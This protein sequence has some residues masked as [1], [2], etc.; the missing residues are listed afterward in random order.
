MTSLEPSHQHL[1]DHHDADAFDRLVATADIKPSSRSAYARDLAH[2]AGWLDHTRQRR[3]LP[4]AP[5]VVVGWI[6]GMDADG[7][8]L[9]T[10]RCR[11][12][13]L[14][15]IHPDP[16]PARTRQV[17]RVIRAI[18]QTCRH[19]A[20]SHPVVDD[21]GRLRIPATD[22]EPGIRVPTDTEIAE[23]R[24]RA[25]LGTAKLG[26]TTDAVHRLLTTCHPDRPIGMRNRALILVTYVSACRR[27]EIAALRLDHLELTPDGYVLLIPDSKTGTRE[28]VLPYGSAPDTCRVRALQTWLE[29]AAIDTGP[30]FR[31]VDRHGNIA[32]RPLRPEAIA[33]VV[34]TAAQAAGID[35][36]RIGAHSLRRGHA[37]QARRNGADT[38]DLKNQ[39]GWASD[40]MVERY[41]RGRPPLHRHLRHPPRPLTPARCTARHSMDASTLETGPFGHVNSHPGRW[42]LAA[43]LRPHLAV[44]THRAAG[45]LLRCP[46]TV[47]PTAR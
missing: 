12:A 37:Q 26:L 11:V 4:L 19:I 41:A 36:T 24:R 3:Q 15:S 28:V 5:E 43:R 44:C 7:A 39:G 35:P 22:D 27:A 31:P 14:S 6:A 16:N 20:A 46:G 17:R 32:D 40:H 45:G 9:S 1:P 18:D 30:V 23:A 8:A 2:L 29:T 42:V 33:A 47:T 25:G 21:H 34:K 10:V 13:A 38:I